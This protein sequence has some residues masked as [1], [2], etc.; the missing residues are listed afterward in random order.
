MALPLRRPHVN[1]LNTAPVKCTTKAQQ[2]LCSC[3]LHTMG[4]IMSPFSGFYSWDWL[5]WGRADPAAERAHGQL[6]ANLQDTP[7]IEQSTGFTQVFFEGI[8]PNANGRIWE[9]SV[10][11]QTATS[12]WLSTRNCSAPVGTLVVQN[13]L[14][15]L[16]Q[17]TSLH[18]L[19]RAQRIILRAQPRIEC[20][21][22]YYGPWSSEQL[23]LM[24]YH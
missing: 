20:K 5:H 2:R 11:S 7:I 18:A 24:Q 9:Y 21:F 17:R 16:V 22:V 15:T 19:A 4:N 1:H 6:I 12:N 13:G 8:D 23:F 10:P 3:G 14:V